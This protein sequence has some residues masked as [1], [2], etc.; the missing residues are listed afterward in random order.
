MKEDSILKVIEA[1]KKKKIKYFT[2]M[3]NLLF[4]ESMADE[5][6]L[7]DIPTLLGSTTTNGHADHSR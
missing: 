6:V 3:D 7:K 1:D 2:I 4:D 5:I